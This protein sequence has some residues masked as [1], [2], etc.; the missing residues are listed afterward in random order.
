M[1]SRRARVGLLVLLVAVAVVLFVVLS[2]GDD[3]GGGDEGSSTVTQ[4]TTTTGTQP[5]VKVIRIANGAPAGGVADLDYDQ[6]DRVRIRVI[7]EQGVEEIHL[8]GYDLEQETNG[9]APVL[10]DFTADI[11]GGF[12]MEAHTHDGEFEIASIKVQP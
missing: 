7:P 4:G 2:G 11:A 8:H 12:E 3:D 1:Q 5:A 6:G 9:T 10:F